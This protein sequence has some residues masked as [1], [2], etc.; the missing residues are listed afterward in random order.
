MSEREGERQRRKEEDATAHAIHCTHP[1][2]HS[3][4]KFSREDGWREYAA[5][6]LFFLHVYRV[7]IGTGREESRSSARARTRD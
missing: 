2:H 6:S 5:P 4:G 1:L 7:S 3:L